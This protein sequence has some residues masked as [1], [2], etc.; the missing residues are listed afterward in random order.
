LSCGVSPCLD[1]S[2]LHAAG[3]LAVAPGPSCCRGHEEGGLHSSLLIAGCAAGVPR[4]GHCGLRVWPGEE[5]QFT[6][7]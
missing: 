3:T 4:L 1:R 7:L 5:I 6:A 2:S